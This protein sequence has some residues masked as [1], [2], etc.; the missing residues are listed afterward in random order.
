MGE[1]YFKKDYIKVAVDVVKINQIR[2]QKIKKNIAITRFYW[3]V[4]KIWKT[5]VFFYLVIRRPKSTWFVLFF[6]R[7][8]LT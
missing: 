5:I 7:K 8:K 2:L 4:S 1:S 3:F 6:K